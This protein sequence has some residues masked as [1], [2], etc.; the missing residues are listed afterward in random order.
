MRP[1]GSGVVAGLLAAC[2][3][4]GAVLLVDALWVEPDWIEVTHHLEYVA[5]WR[6][7]A[8]D[9][10]LVHV[11]DPHVERM[12]RRERRAIEQIAACRPDVI[13]ITGDLVR[14]ARDP[15]SLARFL[16][17]LTARRGTFA[18]WG[19]HDHRS[20]LA[21]PRG[22]ALLR[23]A[24][25]VLLD[26]AHRR[27]ATP[28]GPLVIAGVD[29]PSSG[30]DNLGRAL[31]GVAREDLTILLS[32]SPEIAGALGNH[33]VDLMLSGPTH[34]GQV[35]LPFLGAILT[36]PGT[37]G[38]EDGWFDADGGAR[39]HVSRGLG[40]S[41]LPLRFLCRPR[42]DVITLRGGAPPEPPRRRRSNAA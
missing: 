34:G 39:L 2:L 8:P 24:G 33:D 7:S 12:G 23:S 42:L 5:A 20:G 10:V 15:E 17:A 11:S 4:S 3:L 16:A 13:A 14:G 21:S 32:H 26:N 40:W 36:P 29:D 41:G 28:S 31:K 1:M 27:I 30:A 38:F 19:S 37:R 25:V 6:R 18:V 35:R 9:L 22:E